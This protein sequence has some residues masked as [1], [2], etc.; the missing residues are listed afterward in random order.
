MS[1]AFNDPTY[2]GTFDIRN[3]IRELSCFSL[4]EALSLGARDYRKRPILCSCCGETGQKH[5]L[6]Y[7]I[8]FNR[9][10]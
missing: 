2:R 7:P 6:E 3:V 1:L 4:Y 10:T 9:N 8:Y 5:A